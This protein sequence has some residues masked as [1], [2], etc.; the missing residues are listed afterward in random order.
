MAI[1]ALSCTGLAHGREARRWSTAKRLPT[2]GAGANERSTA[3]LKV[4]AA[5]RGGAADYMPASAGSPT[6][7]QEYQMAVRRTAM[8]VMSAI[9]FGAGTWAVKGRQS[10]L[11]FY[12]G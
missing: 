5:P 6:S 12:T 1:A 11:E 3:L 8:L 9:L 4:S 7:A 10:A 2:A